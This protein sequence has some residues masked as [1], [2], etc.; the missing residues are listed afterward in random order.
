MHI[1]GKVLRAKNGI[2][3]D[4]IQINHFTG[5]TGVLQSFGELL[6]NGVAKRLGTRVGVHC[7]DSHGIVLLGVTID[8]MD[9]YTKGMS[10]LVFCW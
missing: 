7:Q 8:D 4:G 2:E 9:Q 1:T 10:F 6:E 3:A 5:V